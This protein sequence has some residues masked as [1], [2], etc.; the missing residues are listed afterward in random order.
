MAFQT[1]L[2]S[3]QPLTYIHT[4]AHTHINAHHTH[5]YIVL[6]MPEG[7]SDAKMTIKILPFH[8]FTKGLW[9]KEINCKPEGVAEGG[10]WINQHPS[11]CFLLLT[12]LKKRCLH[13]PRLTA[14]PVLS[15]SLPAHQGP[16]SI[17]HTLSWLILKLSFTTKASP[18]HRNVN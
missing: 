6:R 13:L 11:H 8:F 7:L 4:H 9:R 18:P 17:S 14:M 12:S 2:F 10:L 1:F 16:S 5:L 3:T 15:M